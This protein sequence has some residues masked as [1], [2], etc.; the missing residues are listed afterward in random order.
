MGNKDQIICGDALEVLASLPAGSVHCCVTSPP[1]WGLRDYGVDSQLGLEKTPEEYVAKLVEVFREVKRVLR[2]DGTL[3]LNLG[4][5]YNAYNGGAGPGSKLSKTQSEQRPELSTGYG[6]NCKT[7]KPKDLIGIPWR[8]AFALQADGWWLRSDIIWHK[9]NPMPESVR[10]RPTKSH[11]D[12]FLLSKSQRYYYDAD[13]IK[14]PAISGSNGSKFDVGKT[15]EHQL[16]RSSDLERHDSKTRNKRDVWTVSTR[17]FKDAHFAVFPPGLIQPC[18][19]AGTSAH[20]CCPKCAAPWER[21][22]E[23]FDTG[24]RQ[25]M[26]D[27]W[28]TGTGAHGAFHRQG[29]E[30][31]EADKHIIQERTVGWRPTCNHYPQVDQWLEYPYQKKDESDED[32]QDRLVPIRQERQR[33]LAL[34]APMESI[35]CLVLDLFIGSGTTGV[36]AKQ[37]GRHY[38][39]I[40]LNPEYAEM[41]RERI[42][43][44]APMDRLI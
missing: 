11:E 32:Y 34:W 21:V 35:P 25:K 38:I 33:L 20:G 26:P 2:D 16:D 41:A 19:L 22:K 27:G 43:K 24:K 15:A 39:G 10:D 8:V 5:S 40:E 9:P 17:P 28:D 42:K 23:R 12:I 31:G 44:E 30:K 1:Y 14:E 4:D 7:L 36:V 3:W 29:R 18:I 13:A 6:L 37:E